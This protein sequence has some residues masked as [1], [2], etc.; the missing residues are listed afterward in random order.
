MT[1]DSPARITAT[2]ITS[3]LLIMMAESPAGPDQALH[4]VP[5]AAAAKTAGYP[6]GAPARL[7]ARS[8]GPRPPARPAGTTPPES[9]PPPPTARAPTC[10]DRLATAQPSTA[11]AATSPASSTSR[12]HPGRGRAARPDAGRRGG[13][14]GRTRPDQCLPWRSPARQGSADTDGAA[15][16]RLAAHPPSAPPPGRGRPAGSRPGTACP[17]SVRC[18]SRCHSHDA[19]VTAWRIARPGRPASGRRNRSD[20]LTA[21]TLPR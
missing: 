10:G 11:A 3:T 19:T 16:G 20:G 12:R 9:L 17:T 6:A 1:Q 7:P 5:A 8:T 21:K 18:P 2:V 4:A 14:S 13:L 15:A